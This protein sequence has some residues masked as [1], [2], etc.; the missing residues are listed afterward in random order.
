[1]KRSLHILAGLFFL[2]SAQAA[3]ADKIACD[4]DRNIRT[5]CD[6]RNDCDRHCL[7]I[8]AQYTANTFGGGKDGRQCS[9]HTGA[10][11]KAPGGVK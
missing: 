4:S 6:T 3:F 7:S 8:S 9:C 2:A 11:E 10:L 5:K 1:M